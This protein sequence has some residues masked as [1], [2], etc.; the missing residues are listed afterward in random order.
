MVA[1]AIVGGLAFVGLVFALAATIRAHRINNEARRRIIEAA[2][3]RA[4]I[5]NLE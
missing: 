5:V 2:R 3:D 4:R 1:L